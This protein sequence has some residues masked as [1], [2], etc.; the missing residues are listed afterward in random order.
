MNYWT[1]FF[2]GVFVG[3][4]VEWIID[5]LFWRRTLRKIYDNET[6][7]ERELALAR[8]QL[9][10]ADADESYVSKLQTQLNMARIETASIR[11]QRDALQAEMDALHAGAD[12]SGLDVRS[13]LL[14]DLGPDA[15]E[16]GTP[17]QDSPTSDAESRIYVQRDDLE[18]IN[19]IGPVYEKRLYAAGVETYAQLA[20]LSIQELAELVQAEDWQELDYA[21]WIAQAGQFAQVAHHELLPDRLEDISGI[22]PA[23]AKRLRAADIRSFEQLSASSTRQLEE[24]LGKGRL[25]DYASWIEQAKRYAQLLSN[26]RV[27][28]ELERIKGIGPVFAARLELAGIH[29]FQSLSQLSEA[30]LR[31]IIGEAGWPL[32]NYAGWMAQARRLTER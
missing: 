22:G 6:Y 29:T 24:I 15:A 13:G 28:S 8:S 31:E 2:L 26:E 16:V 9:G 21:G 1:I 12:L 27:P 11:Q 5:W 14:V 20:A 23:Y 4:L 25:A 30:Q 7:L 3:W 10:D 17:E 32:V 19:G 18:V